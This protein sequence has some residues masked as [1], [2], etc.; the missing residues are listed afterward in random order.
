[1]KIHLVTG[2]CFEY[3]L[4]VYKLDVRTNNMVY[5]Y[6]RDRDSEKE[7]LVFS[8]PAVAYIEGLTQ[9]QIPLF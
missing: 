3:D 6:P 8:I 4:G 9:H 7:C 2:E 1:M 5:V